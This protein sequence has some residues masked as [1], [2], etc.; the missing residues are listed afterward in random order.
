MDAT[1]EALFAT[2]VDDVVEREHTVEINGET[3]PYK[4]TT[5][6]WVLRAEDG[7]ARAVIFFIAYTRTDVPAVSRPVTFSFN[8]GPGS[9]SV[10]LH[11][12]LLGPRRVLSGDV[13]HVA[14]PP[15][16]LANNEFS[17]LD[18]TD[19]VF[20]DPV[21][22]GFSRPAPGEEAKKFHSVDA[23]IESVGEFIRLWLGRNKR[24]HSPK[25]L[26]GESYGTT[27]AAGLAGHLQDRYGMY[28]NG[29]M[30]ISCVL[31]F[32]T[33][34]FE[35]VHD[36][37]YA[38][39]LPT[40]TATAWYHKR[41]PADLQ[42]S[43]PAAL[44]EATTFAAG[45]YLAALFA[46]S[47][48]SGERRRQTLQTLARLTGLSEAY[49]ESCNLRPEIMRFCRELLRDQRRTV[50]RL[51]SRFQ[52]IE[53]DNAGERIDSDPSY[54][55][56]L[57]PYAGAF[58]Q[59]VRDDLGYQ[60]D[61]PYEV[62]KSLYQSWDYSAYQNRFLDV[63]ETLRAALCQNPHLRVLVANGYF[64]FATPYFATEYTFSHLNLEPEL[65][66]NITLTYYPAGHMMYVHEPSLAQLKSD[67]NMF[68][69]GARPEAEKSQ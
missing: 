38:L 34:H 11:L 62:L 49:L 10:W 65:A 39:H 56:I 63:S 44:A 36:L 69:G 5:G 43:L 27:R 40:Y 21:S 19:L 48:L 28:L 33:L 29:L 67:L 7:K 54:A 51:D 20:I 41:L 50:G 59:Y 17:L 9:S 12:G 4:S 64:D 45:D 26:I 15:Y 14:P 24:W 46:G 60:N 66:G 2:P 31:N 1:T 16:R 47:Q 42:N 25:Y 53:R 37:P 52:G 68:L 32:G 8:G 58:N 13:D 22:T 61:L 23:D 55:A 57:G 30:L 3:I 35:P 6:R 18:R